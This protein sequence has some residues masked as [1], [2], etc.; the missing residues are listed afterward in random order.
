M[1]AD[2]AE[3]MNGIFWKDQEETGGIYSAVT[4]VREVLRD[5]VSYTERPAAA[6]EGG[7][8]PLFPDGKQSGQQKCSMRRPQ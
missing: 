3:L 5:T 6:P 2:L 8:H 7:P 4:R 1:D